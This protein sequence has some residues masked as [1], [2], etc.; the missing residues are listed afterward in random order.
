MTITDENQPALAADLMEERAQA[1]PITD[2]AAPRIPFPTSL[3]LT[4]EQEER[5]MEHAERWLL[6]L[7][8]ELGRDGVTQGTTP[9][10]DETRFMG[11]R[12]LFTMRYYAHVKDR[13][14][15]EPDSIWKHSNI[16]IT[17]AQRITMQMIARSNNY[18]FGTDPW[19]AANFVGVEDRV[20][21]A[22][23]D[24]H[25][26]WKF[27]ITG[28]RRVLEEAVEYAY[29]RGEAVIKTTYQTKERIFRKKGKVLHDGA[30][31]AQI[32]DRTG[33]PVFE[34]DKWEPETEMQM[35]ADGMPML[36]MATGQPVMA[37][38]GR[39][40]LKRDPSVIKPAVAVYKDGNWTKRR[41]LFE[42]PEAK[43]V[44]YKDFLCPLN[45][46]SVDDAEFI[47]H[48]Y[49]MPVM[50]IVQQY[51]RLEAAQTNAEQGLEN[52][53]KAVDAI[54][55]MAGSDG[56]PKSGQAQPRSDF[57]E[58][59]NKAS[60][61]NPTAEIAEC[62]M[63]FD[64]DGDGLPEE[65]MVVIDRK[66]RFP[67]FYDYL[68]NLTPK[69]RRPFTVIRPKAVDSRWYGV[70]AME[71]FKPEQ[72]FIDLC[73]NR[74]NFRSSKSGR[75]TFWNPAATIEGASNPALRLHDGKTYRL[76][77]GY[78][79]EQA[80]AYVT[81]P[82]DSADQMDK[83]NFVSQIMQL[84]SGIIN[85]GDQEASGMPT[86]DTATGVRNVEKSG[87]E[88]FAQF[89][90]SLEPGVQATLQ[91][92]IEVL[93]AYISQPEMF[94][95]FDA[96]ANALVSDTISPEEVEDLEFDVTVLLTRVQT[97][98]TLQMSAESRALILEFYMQYP[99]NLQPIVAP[100]FRDALKALGSENADDLIV[101]QLMPL[102]PA[103]GGPPAADGSAQAEQAP[104]TKG[105]EVPTSPTAQPAT[106]APL[107]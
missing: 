52:L 43:V 9:V 80:L 95:F 83:V 60:Q 29:I 5:L 13:E 14:I 94:R 66:N 20:K 48:I 93:Y 39:H 15:R 98:Q 8:E 104:E 41:T 101:P 71:Y 36:D 72:D 10:P 11:K 53:R 88:M 56:E 102:G 26:K 37:P 74:W 23:V 100:F 58:E 2:P 76:R 57:A 89:L 97:E 107:I 19:Y 62:Y 73:F 24:R 99:P 12:E 50:D 86:S 33:N 6:Q 18:F 38:T 78:T 31:G 28:L 96:G 54:R 69:G 7:E 4:A 1:E 91:Q 87:Q 67:L 3:E 32:F 70:G 90:S 77:E 68:D 40:R 84:K 42:G 65:I 47:A 85:A 79:A 106:P 49:D 25:S 92:Q 16:P 82:D 81:L 27:G 45:T 34:E 59:G 22:K 63:R 30:T 35:G 44:F 21:A 46:P 55:L 103:Q 75:V 61:E 64:A 105:L 51:H 17:M